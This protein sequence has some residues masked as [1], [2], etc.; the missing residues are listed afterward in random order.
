MTRPRFAPRFLRPTPEAI[1]AART[2]AGHTQEQAARSVFCG[3]R[4]WKR[5]ERGEGPMPAAAWV[6]YR[7]RT[8]QLTLEELGGPSG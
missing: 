8:G 2:A 1:L 6:L 4:S 7:L 3:L 5:W